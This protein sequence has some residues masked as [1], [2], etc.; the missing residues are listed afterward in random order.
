MGGRYD[1]VLHSPPPEEKYEMVHKGPPRPRA[2]RIY[3]CHVGMSSEE[4]KVGTFRE[5]AR[6]VLPRAKTAGFNC[7]QLMAIQEHSYYASFGYHVTNL[8]APTSRCGTPEDLKYMIDRAHNMG[9][10]VVA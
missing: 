5:F 6:D 2:P 1:A 3:E 9:L 10:S 7:V 8:F 4:E